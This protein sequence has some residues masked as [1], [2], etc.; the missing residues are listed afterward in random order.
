MR[1]LQISYEAAKKQL[2]F[3]NSARAEAEKA[4]MLKLPPGKQHPYK[5]T[6]RREIPA[7][8]VDGKVTLRVLVDRASLELFVNDGMAAASFVIIPDAKNRDI[9][10]TGDA[11]TKV[12]RLEVNEL[13]SMW[14]AMDAPKPMQ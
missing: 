3:T 1:G 5:D 4:G 7:P 11:A 8:E 9:L 10:L 14:P 2:V 6:G 13:K 12:S